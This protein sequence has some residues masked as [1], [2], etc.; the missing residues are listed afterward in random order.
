MSLLKINALTKSYDNGFEALKSVNLEVQE[1]EIL[2]LLGPNGAGKT[3]LISATCGLTS[4]TSGTISVSGF[5]IVKDRLDARRQIALVPQEIMLEP[6][7]KVITTV[8]LSRGLFGLAPDEALIETILRRLSLWDKRNS[9]N[10][11]LSGG[12]KRRV[13]IAKALSH[14]PKLLFLDEPS[15]GVDVELRNDMWKLVEE[16]K[17]QGVT[18]ILTTHYI[19]EAEEVAD[20]VAI[21]NHGDI[22]LVE[23]KTNLMERLGKKELIIE[24]QEPAAEIA[25]TLAALPLTLSD[26]GSKLTY[27]YDAKQERTGITKLLAK[28]SE[29]GMRVK[30]L[31]THTSSLEDIF[32]SLVQDEKSEDALSDKGAVR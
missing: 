20:R 22:L 9:R 15:A 32:V 12:M 18:I 27:Y 14:N 28:M 24:L 21:I 29:A 19:E 31:Q 17:A 16:L 7:E 11:T 25:S 30:D 6:F 8:R 13:M 10:M 5:D 2:A 26:D 4:I 1:G 23:E 3:T